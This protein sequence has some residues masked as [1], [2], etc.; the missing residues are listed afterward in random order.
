LCRHSRC[1][2]H[3]TQVTAMKD[4]WNEVIEYHD[5]YLPGVTTNISEASHSY[6]S[7]P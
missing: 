5:V 6:H 2:T 7:P 4:L 1:V 3:P